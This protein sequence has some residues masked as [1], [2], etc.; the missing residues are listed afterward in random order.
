MKLVQNCH[1]AEAKLRLYR[2]QVVFVQPN[3]MSEDNRV[4]I[5]N[6]S[7]KLAYCSLQYLMLL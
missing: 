6:E 5:R 1:I 7:G 4:L 2:D 3:S